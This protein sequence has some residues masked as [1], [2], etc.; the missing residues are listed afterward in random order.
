MTV[1]DDDD[2]EDQS[3]V[4]RLRLIPAD[5]ICTVVLLVLI[6]VLAVMTD[7][8]P[9]LFGFLKDI[10]VDDDCPP[11]PFGVNYYIYPVVWGG[12]G[13]AITAAIIGPAVSLLKGWYMCFWPAITVV[14]V[15]LSA[16]IGSLLSTVH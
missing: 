7:W 10:C 6:V 5:V 16:L 3:R 12:I 13:A 2:S 15:L 11:V 4:I 1:A 9:A 8:W 14:L